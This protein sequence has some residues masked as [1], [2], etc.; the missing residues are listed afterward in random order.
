VCPAT[1]LSVGKGVMYAINGV[2][3]KTPLY[4]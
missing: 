3:E 1:D 2:K 4:I